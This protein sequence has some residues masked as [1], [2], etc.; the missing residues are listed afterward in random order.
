[1]LFIA[2]IN[3]GLFFQILYSIAMMACGIWNNK[4]KKTKLLCIIMTFISFIAILFSTCIFTYGNSDNV[5]YDEDAVIIL[6]AGIRGDKVSPN[7]QKRLDKAVE[8]YIK[9]AT[10]VFVVTGGRGEQE[11]IT[12]AL[13]MERYLTS[14]G[15]PNNQIIR[16]EKATSTFENFTFSKDI[17]RQRFPH[18]YSIVFITNN[19]HVYRAE[20]IAKTVNISVNHLGA[21]TVWY[22]IPMNYLRESEILLIFPRKSR[23]VCGFAP[24]NFICNF[25]NF[26]IC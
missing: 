19:F 26:I 2:N 5:L 4:F 17:L 3:F 12:E 16:E 15:I 18:E 7:L 13:A 9:N 22:T 1:M 8:Y 25:F 23:A 10:A 14:K 6:G 21:D 24:K 20:S 11:D